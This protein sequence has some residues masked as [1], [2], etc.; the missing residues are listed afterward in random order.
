MNSKQAIY[1]AWVFSLLALFA[2]EVEAAQPGALDKGMVNP[3]YEEK[4]DWFKLSFLDIREDVEEAAAEGKRVLLYFYQDGCPYC[5]KL[6]RDNFSQRAIVE[7]TQK[8]FDVIAINIW[9]DKEVIDINGT[10]VIEKEFA[11]SLRIMYTPTL[12]FLDERGKVA[13]RV[14][15]YY[16]PE[17]FST[18]LD[19]VAQKMETK[20][21]FGDYYRSKSPLPATGKLHIDP[22]YLKPPY[23]LTSVA[24][25]VKNICWSYLNKNSVRPVMNFIRIFFSVQGQKIT[26]KDLI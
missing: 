22:S 2:A 6:L 1:V 7:K 11:K 18:A 25:K 10:E 19:Y 3:G 14:N 5:A 13:L 24:R 17:K 4:P 21:G 26:L 8:H 16:F 23:N 20:I 12:L 9:G 15:G